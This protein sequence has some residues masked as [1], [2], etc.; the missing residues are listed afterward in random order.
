MK[1]RVGL[2]FLAMAFCLLL[3]S[4]WSAGEGRAQPLESVQQ[5]TC[6]A[7]CNEQHGLVKGWT[8][9]DRSSQGQGRRHCD[10]RMTL[11]ANTNQSSQDLP[12]QCP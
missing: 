7:V 8:G 9:P 4:S 10:L 12:R 5:G 11:L 1:K 2:L 3:P 6:H